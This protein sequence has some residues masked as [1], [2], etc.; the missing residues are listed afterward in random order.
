MD[1]QRTSTKRFAF[2]FIVGTAKL[3]NS[4]SVF[5]FPGKYYLFSYTS[6]VNRNQ[7]QIVFKFKKYIRLVFWQYDSKYLFFSNLI[8]EYLVSYNY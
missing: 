5:L 6:R 8:L 1:I 2:I 4:L 3:W 7:V